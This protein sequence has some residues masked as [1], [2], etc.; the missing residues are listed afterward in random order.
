[1]VDAE[2]PQVQ[3]D[4]FQPTCDG[5]TILGQLGKGGYGEVH[6]V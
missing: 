3:D 5:Y 1:M 6:L 4:D 2:M